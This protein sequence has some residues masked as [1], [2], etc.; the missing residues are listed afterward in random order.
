MRRIASALAIASLA[1]GCGRDP[2]GQPTIGAN[3]TT[4]PTGSAL[5]APNAPVF[6]CPMDRD[7]RSHDPG[8]CPRC[9]MALVA[10]IPDPV[11]YQLELDVT[12]S[13]RPGDSAHLNFRVLDPWKENPVTKFTI[14]HEK[15]G[16]CLQE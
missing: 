15:R 7:V 8:T 16:A 10:G 1:L 4:A 6:M 11:E 13:P 2:A 12:P 9:G 14:I 3:A 5:P